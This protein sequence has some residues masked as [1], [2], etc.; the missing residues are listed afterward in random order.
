[1]SVSA[2]ILAAGLGERL[3]P[4]TDHFPKPLLPILGKPVLESV[5]EKVAFLPAG[6]IGINIHY[7]K[8]IIEDYI[9]N[10]P[11]KGSVSL[12]PEDP[13]L[14]TGG[15]LK[16]AEVFLQ[17]NTFLVHNADIVSD[18]EL[19]RLLEFHLS[20]G[21]L[22]TLAVHDCPA[23]N[24]LVTDDDGLLIEIGAMCSLCRDPRS[25]ILAF[26]GIAVYDPG[27]LAFLPE[28][29][30]SVVHAWQQAVNAGSRIGTFDVTGCY[31]SD[32][33]T[34]LTYARTLIDELRKSGE[35]IYL[36]PSA[37]WCRETE[38]DGFV[39]LEGP[40]PHD[41][42]LM[43]KGTFLRNCVVL[44]G[45]SLDATS[46]SVPLVGKPLSLVRSLEGV[47]FEN[48]ILGPG[49]RIDLNEAEMLGG[50]TV[51]GPVLI[52][53]GGSDRRY[54]RVM[55]D[56]NSV[57]LMKSRDD[58]PDFLRQLEYTRFFRKHSVPVPELLGA[59]PEAASAYFE[60]LGDLSL[61]AWLKCP[62]DRDQI[63]EMFKKVL[64]ALVIMHTNATAHV[65]ECPL[66]EQRRFDYEH[67]RWET[68]YFLERFVDGIESIDVPDPSAVNSEFHLLALWVDSF[69]KTIVHRDFQ[70][71]N[72][73]VVR[74]GVPRIIDYQGARIGPPAYDVVS[75]LWDPYHR[76]DD[77]LREDLLEHYIKRMTSYAGSPAACGSVEFS[78]EDFRTTLLPCRMQRHMQALG[79]YGY[80]SRVKGKK[81]F[82]KYVPE[83]LRLLREVSELAK[84]DY[85]EL[86]RLVKRLQRRD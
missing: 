38:M 56:D 4:I 40:S 29:L 28:G 16:N 55:K 23:F 3:R 10:S 82:L 66:L 44:P 52:G 27:F 8:E 31:W 73:M 63:R 14:G 11:F 34:P 79:A 33:G 72:I 75:I 58:D 42:P 46:S 59:G 53:A 83:A 26:T 20:S 48:A 35:T 7:K 6:K 1:M 80:L 25:R 18:I 51:D 21:N 54:Y 45:A 68:R 76:L 39:V 12:F 41:P 69:A 71:Q 13:V 43:K 65:S 49:F 17:G 70:S 22:A 24:K 60:D 64:D 74:N 67:L 50:E 36:H 57:V 61:Y 9:N 81:H 78:A 5:M 85:P 30:S 86:H 62:R 15:A 32:I 84:D 47:S 19:G 77:Q 37:D 2:F